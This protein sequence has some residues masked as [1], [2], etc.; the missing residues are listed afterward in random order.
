MLLPMSPTSSLFLMA[1][2]REAPMHVGSL[3]LFEP[4]PGADALDVR[5]MFEAALADSEVAPVFR[6]RPRRSLT[7]LGQWGWEADRAFDLEHHVRRS[8]LPRPGRVLELLVLC[9]RLH[10]TLLDRQRPLWEVHLVE[11]LH[12]GRYA[13]YFKIHHSLMDGVSALRLLD[14]TLSADP[15][16]RGMAAPWAPR[17]PR[18]KRKQSADS[19]VLHDIRKAVGETAG[20]AP[21]LA[22]TVSRALSEQTAAMSFS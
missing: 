9:S 5:A 7:T 14:R 21:A 10:S 22:R 3:Q 11:G 18:E 19:S 1:E 8:A 17:P 20:L 4:P 2:T 13:L 6:K 12:D 16:E 15:D